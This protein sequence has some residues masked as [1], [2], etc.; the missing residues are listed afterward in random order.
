A[1]PALSG[2]V[3]NAW[4]DRNEEKIVTSVCD[5]NEKTVGAP[6]ES[7]GPKCTDSDPASPRRLLVSTVGDELR[8]AHRESKVI[9]ISIK[10]R[11]AILPSGHRAAGAYWFDDTTGHF[12]SSTFYMNQLAK[13]AASFNNRNLAATYVDKK[14]EGFPK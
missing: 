1:M 11:G 9:G 7:A 13:W 5:W 4:Y 12:V 2:I 10:A 6:T 3:G 14:W 8:T